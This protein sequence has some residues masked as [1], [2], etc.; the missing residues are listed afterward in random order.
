MSVIVEI[1]KKYKCGVIT[2]IYLTPLPTTALHFW[3]ENIVST[4]HFLIYRPHDVSGI[5]I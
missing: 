5:I 2:Y 1:D 3:R 4:V